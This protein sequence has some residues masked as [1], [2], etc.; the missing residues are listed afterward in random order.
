MADIPFEMGLDFARRMDAGDE[1]AGF[2]K[3]F[4]FAE[5]DLIYA[6]GNSL[7][8]LTHESAARVRALVDA[9]WGR[10]LIRGWNAGWFES[11]RR[12]GDKISQLIGAAP[13]EVLVCDSTSVNLFK[14]AMAAL[15]MRWERTR[16][17]SDALNF[18]SDLYIIQGCVDL[19]GRRHTL[20]LVPSR[21][22][23]AVSEQAMLNAI[24]TRT[25]LVTLSHVV[26]KSGFLH[27]MQAITEQAHAVGALVLWDVSHA[28]GVIPMAL[29]E[30]GVDFAVGCTY[31][32]LN[33]GPGS[34]AFL[35]VRRELQEEV[36]SPLWGWLG[37][38]APFDFDLDYSPAEG[39]GRFLV[40]SPPILSLLTMEAAL[41]PLLAAGLPRLRAK[42][43]R[44]TE[45]MIYLADSMLAPLGFALG[46]PRD[47][48]RRGSHVSLRHPDG[49]RI[50]RALIEEMNVIGDF[51]TPDNLRLGFAP[52]YTSFVDVWET[53]DRIRRVVEGG[54][55]LRYPEDRPAVT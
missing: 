45:Y 41:E 28:V 43:I 15:K 6:D 16:I 31:K 27:D 14:L 24:D 26:F 44:L 55:H 3:A 11:P 1:L 48:A 40:G 7:G 47:S 20:H 37:Q 13:G 30:W 53:A 12:V 38:H 34:P 21:D 2:R 35:Y 4:V 54:R 49:Y 18:P 51:R 22:G 9:E 19:L 33:G 32:Y 42:S 29:D 46:S 8:R 23:I 39:I 10:G 25:A 17:V 52:I 50:N 36:V 5:P